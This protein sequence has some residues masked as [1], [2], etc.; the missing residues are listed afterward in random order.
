MGVMWSVPDDEVFTEDMII[1]MWRV[2]KAIVKMFA[3]LIG[4]LSLARAGGPYKLGGMNQ[5]GFPRMLEFPSFLD[6]MGTDEIKRNW[7]VHLSI[8]IA[9]VAVINCIMQEHNAY[10]KEMLELQKVRRE[11]QQNMHAEDKRE[12]DATE[13]VHAET[14]ATGDIG[15]KGEKN[16]KDD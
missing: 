2:T 13:D 12:T 5:Y 3:I 15:E 9:T 10:I 8:F 14:D 4:V 16:K 7:D 11:E 6:M 1:D